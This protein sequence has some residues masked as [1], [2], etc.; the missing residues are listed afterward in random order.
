MYS[1]KTLHIYCD[2]TLVHCSDFITYIAFVSPH[3]Y[4]AL[5]AQLATM[6]LAEWID[7]IFIPEG[8]FKSSYRKLL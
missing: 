1:E 7:A 8:F 3:I 2:A 4:N 5:K 6:S